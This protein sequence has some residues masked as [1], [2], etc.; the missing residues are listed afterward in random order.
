M[1]PCDSDTAMDAGSNPAASTTLREGVA[2]LAP[3]NLTVAHGE[4]TMG[5]RDGAASRRNRVA[6][7]TAD[8][9]YGGG[10]AGVANVRTDVIRDLGR[11]YASFAVS[12]AGLAPTVRQAADE[13]GMSIA[14]TYSRIQRAVDAGYLTAIEMEGR[15]AKY[16]PTA[17]AFALVG[18]AKGGL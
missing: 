7:A 15:G 16:Q 4:A 11:Y 12:H 10:R 18:N 2:A 6:T 5:N 9:G 14:G 8:A 17:R 13:Y 3:R 1:P